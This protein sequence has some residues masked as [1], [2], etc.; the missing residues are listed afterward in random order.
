LFV[1]FF[2]VKHSRPANRAEP[3][4]E[5]GSLVA[6][7]NILGCGA[8]DLVGCGKAGQRREDTAGST[9]TSEAVANADSEWFTLNF[10]TQLSAGT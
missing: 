9:L 1:T 10:N 5:L 8:K 6:N 2:R 4:G 7:A 3:K